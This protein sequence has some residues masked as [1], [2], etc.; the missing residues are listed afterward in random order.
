MH[1]FYLWKVFRKQKKKW[2]QEIY[3]IGRKKHESATGAPLLISTPMLQIAILNK[4]IEGRWNDTLFLKCHC[5]GTSLHCI[6]EKTK[7]RTW[8]RKKRC[9]FISSCNSKEVLGTSQR[10]LFRSHRIH[11]V[12]R[13]VF[14]FVNIDPRRGAS[15]A[16]HRMRHPGWAVQQSA[17]ARHLATL[18]SLPPTH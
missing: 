2:I 17:G 10:W 14:K 11:T 12:V 6:V 3:E 15:I 5:S 1:W 7:L 8:T 13:N 16:Y 18:F 4:C 9:L